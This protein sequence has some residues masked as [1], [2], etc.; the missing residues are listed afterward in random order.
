TEP[1]QDGFGWPRA[2]FARDRR[3]KLYG[4]YARWPKKRGER[5]VKTGHLYDL[6]ADPDED[7]PI[8]P[9]ADTPETA[10]ARRRLAAA[11]D[12]LDLPP[13]QDTTPRRRTR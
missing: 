4:Y 5:I 6:A 1:R 12:S 2:R 13:V 11:L 3:W 7:A 8:L 10:A 9:A